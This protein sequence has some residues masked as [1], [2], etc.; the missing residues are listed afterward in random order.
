MDL[1]GDGLNLAGIGAA[2]D[3]EVVGEGRDFP[4]IQHPN[5]A[6]L[7]FFRGSHRF[8]PHWCGR[9]WFFLS[10]ATQ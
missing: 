5:V 2:Q 6:G 7:F 8:Q 9:L 10:Y 1:V 4:Q 3:Y